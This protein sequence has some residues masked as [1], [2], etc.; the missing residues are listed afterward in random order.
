MWHMTCD[1]WHEN[2]NRWHITCDMWHVSC[3]MWHVT[4]D[5]WNMTCDIWQ[6]TSDKWQVTSD[7]WHVTRD[8]WH[9]TC[10]MSQVKSDMW[11]VTC[12]MSHVTCHMRHVTCNMWLLIFIH[13]LAHYYKYKV[14]YEHYHCYRD[15]PAMK[16]ELASEYSSFTSG[17]TSTLRLGSQITSII[18]S[19]NLTILMWPLRSDRF[20]NT[21]E[22]FI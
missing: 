10:H 1:R 21:S 14:N 6:V 12:D 4:C 16:V 20:M 9:V 17:N 2:C 11:H 18:S 8:M 7:M 13:H 3:D 19:S 15:H 5:M 22:H